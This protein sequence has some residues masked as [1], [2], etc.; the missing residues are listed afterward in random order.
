MHRETT[1]SSDLRA[2]AM[3]NVAVIAVAVAPAAVVGLTWNSMRCCC[4]YFHRHDHSSLSSRWKDGS[5][6]AFS[7]SAE[8]RP[9]LHQ[10]RRQLVYGFHHLHLQQNVLMMNRSAVQHR[11]FLQARFVQH[12]CD[13]H[14]SHRAMQVVDRPNGMPPEPTRHLAETGVRHHSR[15]QLGFCRCCHCCHGRC[16]AT[17]DLLHWNDGMRNQMNAI[18]GAN[19][20]QSVAAWQR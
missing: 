8:S 7:A 1:R 12:A 3:M 6:L 13:Q 15:C 16:D 18:G 2:C 19:D 11:L 14:Y 4:C 20:C 10:N 9:S 5:M 17:A